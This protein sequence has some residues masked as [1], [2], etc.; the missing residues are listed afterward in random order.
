MASKTKCCSLCKQV[1]ELSEFR[2]A[3]NENGYLVWR[4]RCQLCLNNVGKYYYSLK[5]DNPDYKKDKAER[6]KKYRSDNPEIGKEARKLYY[7]K[8]A[9]RIRMFMSNFHK[10]S[11]EKL[12]DDY[13]INHVFHRDFKG[14]D[15]KTIPKELI[16]LKKHHILLKRKLKSL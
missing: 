5:K 11:A 6:A 13:I 12:T 9:E 16:E 3:K 7:D 8:N 2:K 1:K 10:R 4:S 15:K 14:I